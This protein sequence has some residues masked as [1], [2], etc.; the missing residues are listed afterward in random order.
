M[1]QPQS[2][3]NS[4]S[5]LAGLRSE[6][7]SQ[8]LEQIASLRARGVGEHIDLPQLVVCGDQSAGKSSVLE[9]IT[10]LPFPRQDGVCTKFATEIILSHTEGPTSISAEIIPHHSRS[11]ASKRELCK[12]RQEMA[13]FSDLP[14]VIEEVGKTLGI[15]G[16]GLVET[17][18]A[19]VEDVLRIKVSGPTGLHLTVVDLP[20]LISVANEEQTEEDVQTVHSLIDSYA[21]NP[22]TILLAVVQ[23]N[24][25]ITNQGIIQKSK[26]YDKSGQRT[27][28]IITKPD[29]I[30]TGTERRIAAL[31]KNQD[32]T[33]LKLGYFLLKNPSPSELASGV[34]Q[35]QRERTELNYFAS[36]PWK[37]QGLEVERV[38]VATLRRFL[39][40]LLDQH[41]EKELPKVREEIKQLIKRTENEI[42]ALG[43]ERPTPGHLRMF[44][45]RI[46]MRFHN[47]ATAALQGDYH[48]VD[49]PF[50]AD[51]DESPTYLRFRA[52]VHNANTAFA[53]DM[54][55]N[56]QTMKVVQTSVIDVWD[57][58]GIQDSPEVSNG[59]GL[60][61]EGEMKAFVLKFYKKTRGRELPGNYNHALLTELFHHQS[62]KWNAMAHEHLADVFENLSAFVKGAVRYVSADDQISL[63]MLD[64][65]ESSLLESKQTSEEEL[66]KLCEDEAQQPITY[67]HYY[68]DNVQK[69]RQAST[70]K[71][72]KKAMKDASIEYY[73][74][75]LHISNTAADGEK[76]LTALQR[77]ILIDMDD[78][79]CSEVLAGFSAYYKVARKTFV[80]NVCKQVI[81]RH[82]LRS[83]PMMFSP[84]TVASYSD[85]EMKR[86]AGE[87]ESTITKRRQLRV[88]HEI[89]MAGFRDLRR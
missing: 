68:T 54:R 55:E 15:R 35:E 45:S 66:L 69:A 56:G 46:A 1:S 51:P 26:K 42:N 2:V 41:I 70:R 57:S 25:D 89:L 78:Q 48:G 33:K 83:L 82:L 73:N 86:I 19:F 44:L 8:R 71:W 81:E 77:Q 21:Q 62:K 50:F 39:Q 5:T 65:I 49:T 85:E 80:D 76:L 9:G 14:G 64:R 31:A 38:G 29:L 67:N 13:Q 17:G 28:G 53:N 34:T 52:F 36:S 47:L 6:R 40:R 12:Y 72:I 63:E 59:Q 37:E 22:R 27:V 18:P 79:A 84:E 7:S 24:N 74:G 3:E 61:T 32:T 10:G 11:D 43:E 23:A 88:M 16:F 30:N 58:D 87:G 20:G 4:D 60:V 75:K